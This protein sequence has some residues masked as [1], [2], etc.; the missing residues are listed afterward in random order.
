M[1]TVEMEIGDE[2]TEDAAMTPVLPMLKETTEK[3][4]DQDLWLNTKLS[5]LTLPDL[6]GVLRHKHNN[7]V[8]VV[9]ESSGQREPA[10]TVS[11]QMIDEGFR[12]KAARLR[13]AEGTSGWAR[14][15]RRYKW[16]AEG[17]E[18]S[19]KAVEFIQEHLRSAAYKLAVKVRDEKQMRANQEPF[20]QWQPGPKK[21]QRMTCE[22]ALL[23]PF[24]LLPPE[25]KWEASGPIHDIEKAE[26]AFVYAR[27]EYSSLR[28]LVTLQSDGSICARLM[29]QNLLPKAWY[30]ADRKR[31]VAGSG[32]EAL[33]RLPEVAEA[34]QH[35]RE[36]QRALKHAEDTVER[37]CKGAS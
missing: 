36:A 6:V 37:V 27:Y 11:K 8:Y 25:G 32:T 23:K 13:I 4:L 9:L 1:G 14:D 2:V 5:G 22:D 18:L 16:P 21:G 35:M 7:T 33:D 15:S 34:L 28:F 31:H 12:S 24:K 30:F 29:E 26:D 20:K 3:L 17:G 19:R 10:C